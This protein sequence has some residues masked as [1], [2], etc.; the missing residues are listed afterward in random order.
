MSCV[1]YKGNEKLL[2]DAVAVKGM[3][4]QGWSFEPA[5]IK[6]PSAEEF[7]KFLNLHEE[8]KRVSDAALTARDNQIADL[9]QQNEQLTEDIEHLEGENIEVRKHL[10]I[11]LDELKAL[12]EK[13]SEPKSETDEKSVSF[14]KVVELDYENLTVQQLKKHARKAEIPNYQVMNKERLI[15]ALKDGFKSQD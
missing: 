10:V 2:V 6:P 14:I 7:G 15:K 11:A 3:L 1:I 5:E 13:A 4:A 12:K 9:T 8:L